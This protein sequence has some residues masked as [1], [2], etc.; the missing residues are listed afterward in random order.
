MS[1]LVGLS[2]HLPPAVR[3]PYRIIPT[4]FCIVEATRRERMENSKF[5][6]VIIDHH[7]REG[8]GTR[9]NT[10]LYDDVTMTICDNGHTLS[11]QCLIW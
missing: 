9:L 5:V 4:V 10:A 3:Q 2:Q 1:S 8:L 7:V 6:L 11:V